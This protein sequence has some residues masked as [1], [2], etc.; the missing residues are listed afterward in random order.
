MHV[1][2][3]SCSIFLHARISPQRRRPSAN[4]SSS[5]KRSMRGT[6]V[7]TFTRMCVSNLS[8]L[9]PLLFP[10]LLAMPAYILSHPAPP[11]SALSLPPSTPPPPICPSFLSH[12]PAN[13]LPP[14]KVWG[15]WVAGRIEGFNCVRTPPAEAATEEE[16]EEEV[17]PPSSGGYSFQLCVSRGFAA[18]SI[19][20]VCVCVC[21]SVCLLGVRHQAW[22]S[23]FVYV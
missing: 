9:S 14:Q 15:D 18:P 12:P 6:H 5:K 23:G 21:V 20:M 22:Q 11:L 2:F 17:L 3:F 4:F 7:H 19:W 10:P 13:A 8:C 16:E 1:F